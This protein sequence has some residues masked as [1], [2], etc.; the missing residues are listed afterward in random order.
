VKQRSRCYFRRH[1]EPARVQAINKPGQW[2]TFQIKLLQLQIEQ[3][4]KIIKPQIFGQK[5]VELVAVNGDMP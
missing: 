4:A 5:A 3:R 2:F 1:T